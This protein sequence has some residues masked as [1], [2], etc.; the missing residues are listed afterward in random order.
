VAEQ[1][2]HAA[3]AR[4]A[5]IHYGALV[6]AEPDFAA[7]ASRIGRLSLR[8]DDPTAAVTWLQRA[9]AAGL[10]DV[11]VL[12]S[13]ADAQLRTGDRNGAQATIAAALDKEPDNPILI[14]LSRRAR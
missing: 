1:R 14:A 6:T 5:L 2:N 4:T 8:L 11:G 12:V 3:L 9:T 10:R 13:L 7:R